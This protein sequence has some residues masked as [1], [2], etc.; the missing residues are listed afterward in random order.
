MYIYYVNAH[1]VDFGEI[2][3]VDSCIGGAVPRVLQCVVVCHNVLQCVKV[4][5]SVFSRRSASC[6]TWM[7]Q[8]VAV[9]CNV[10]QCVAICCNVV[11][12]VSRG[13]AYTSAHY[14]LLLC[15]DTLRRTATQRHTVT[16]N[17]T[18]HH[19]A[20]LKFADE[21]THMHSH[22]APHCN[23]LQHT[24][25]TYAFTYCFTLD[26]TATHST[27]QMRGVGYSYASRPCLCNIF[28][29][30]SSQSQLASKFTSQND[31]SAHFRLLICIKALPM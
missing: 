22:T 3:P 1:E 16:R 24:A 19:T 15:I 5:C 30:I 12:Y 9:R 13:A 18:Q 2:W 7:M 6:H 26:H 20:P 23:T 27:P 10:L 11:Q 21:V 8:C 29:I 25:Y 14:T 4:C 31:C 17:T 28:H